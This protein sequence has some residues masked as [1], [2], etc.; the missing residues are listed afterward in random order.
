MVSHFIFIASSY[1][2]GTRI[3]LHYCDEDIAKADYEY[4]IKECGYGLPISTHFVQT[5][6]SDWSSV[7]KND[8]FFK[9]VKV[10]SSRD[11]FID[12]VMHDQQLNGLDIAKYIL[13]KIRCTHLKLEKLVYF[14][15]ADYL[16]D[17]GE[18]LFLD[19][20]YAY[21]L[22]P[23]IDSVY[24]KYRKSGKGLL[25]REDNK[26]TYD[27]YLHR[28]PIKSRIL[29]SSNGIKK[30]DSINKTIE[31]YK[32]LSPNDLVRLTHKK[33]TPWSMSGSG[34]ELNIEI[35]D[36]LIIKHHKYEII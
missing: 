5:N 16:C 9:D 22:G 13:T 31:K 36:S 12:L 23:V 32:D 19:K 26:N 35:S 2:L 17:T 15:Y 6:S 29:V 24:K 34:D 3:V 4:I 20:I 10:I 30:L 8:K 21:R 27:E 18:K 25:E 28:M 7:V 33:S 11:E 14:C 1:S